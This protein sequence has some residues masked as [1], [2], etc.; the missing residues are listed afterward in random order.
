VIKPPLAQ[1]QILAWGICCGGTNNKKRA[2]KNEKK[3]S[4][5]PGQGVSDDF[6]FDSD[7]TTGSNFATQIHDNKL[8]KLH[9]GVFMLLAIYEGFP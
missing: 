8:H 5:G 2:T 7:S 3:T 6:N 1:D 4:G 9:S